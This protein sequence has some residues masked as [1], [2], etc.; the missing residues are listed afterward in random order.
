M[1]IH[2]LSLVLTMP[3]M[4][5]EPAALAAVNSTLNWLVGVLVPSVSGADLPTR[6]GTVVA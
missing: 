6:F 5:L 3:A 2:P 4:A 1:L